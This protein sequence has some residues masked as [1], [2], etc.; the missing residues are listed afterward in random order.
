MMELARRRER[1][2]RGPGA[3]EPRARRGRGSAS[4]RCWRSWP[5]RAASSAICW[6]RSRR[7]E[8]APDPRAARRRRRRTTSVARADPGLDAL[9]A[10]GSGPDEWTTGD[11]RPDLPARRGSEVAD[12]SR[13]RTPASDCPGLVD[14]HAH[15]QHERFDADRDAVIERAVD[16][17]DRAHLR[18]GLGP[19]LVGGGARARRPRIPGSIDAAVGVHPHHAC[20]DGRGRPGRGSRRSPPKPR[21][22]AV[23]EIGLD[24]FRNLSPPDVQREALARQ[25]GDR[26]RAAAC[27]CSS[28]T[29]RRTR[30]DETLRCL[31][32]ARA[33]PRASSMPSPATGRWRGAS[34]GA[35]FVISFALPVAFRIGASARARPRPRCRSGSFLVETDA[36]Y[37]GPDPPARNEPTTALRVVAELA[38]LRGERAEAL[39]RADSRRRTSALIG[40]LSSRTPVRAVARRL[41][42]TGEA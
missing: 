8:R 5:R 3:V 39:V 34:S 33:R 11:G 15:L 28:T 27:R 32:R 42:R 10:W 26:R 40:P 20:R 17:R 18:P 2:R 14:S 41:H 19:R 6:R 23:G 29:A 16:G 31:G 7:P 21:P 13:R 25:L 9:L 37:L 38:R 22:R 24:F 30:G 36:P 1:L 35:G 12:L 4:A